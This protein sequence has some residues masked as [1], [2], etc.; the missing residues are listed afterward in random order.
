LGYDSA[1]G[2]H[3]RHFK[4]D[5][6]DVDYRSFEEL[7]ERFKSEWREL[8]GKARNAAGRNQD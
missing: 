4:G 1:H 5:M 6:S 8:I 2:R 7:E 3:H